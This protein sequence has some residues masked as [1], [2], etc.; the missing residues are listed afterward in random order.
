V[1]RPRPRR[2]SRTSARRCALEIS[3]LFYGIRNEA[4][5]AG[6]EDVRIEGGGP[7]AR[8]LAAI[9]AFGRAMVGASAEETVALARFAIEGGVLFEADPAFFPVA[10]IIVLTLADRDEA[11]TAWDDLRA[12]AHRHGSVLGTTSVNL[13]RGFTLLW[14]GELR[15]A[16]ESLLAAQE[17]F[18]DWGRA[19]SR[20]TYAPAFLPAVRVR[21]GDLAG[22]RRVLEAAQ[23]EDDGSDA[24]GLLLRS[25]SGLLLG[26]GRHAEALAVAQDH[27]RRQEFMV[28]PG[29]R[30]KRSHQARALDGLGRTDE[31]LELLREELR[32]ARRFGSPS[33]VG[34]PL[35]LLGTL[36]RE[37]GLDHLHEAVELLER[38]TARFEHAAA[39]L[40]LGTA[41]RLRRSPTEA[42][43]PLRHALEL[44]DLCGAAGL[45]EQARTELHATGA[46]PRTTALRGAAALTASE[47]RVAELAAAG[48]SNKEVAQT[49]YVTPKTVEVH[50]SS[51]YRKLGIRSRR[52][53]ERALAA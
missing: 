43:E 37:R 53:L 13:W 26:E 39:L 1:P 17:R 50:L 33:V 23:R 9:S 6:L 10:A 34:R 3:S 5:V 36:E 27:A 30:P 48:R 29:W 15:E 14:R 35:R 8:M 25:W 44:A 22:A 52:D 18:A 51:T 38:S 7:G 47:R 24:H 20:D 42:R 46:R 19:R 4:G 2:S 49:L 21:R 31:A 16:E 28:H 32:I 40:S 11:L 41:L 45:A 12:L